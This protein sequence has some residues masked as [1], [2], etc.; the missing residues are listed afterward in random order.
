MKQA[1]PY[2]FPMVNAPMTSLP[3]AL[4]F[5]GVFSADAAGLEEPERRRTGGLT[6]LDQAGSQIQNM[7][8]F[9]VVFEWLL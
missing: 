1:F 3:E 6:C 7:S 9:F 8:T 5:P 2:G 4:T